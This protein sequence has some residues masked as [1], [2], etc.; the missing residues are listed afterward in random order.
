MATRVLSKEAL[1]SF[2]MTV[3]G[4]NSNDHNLAILVDLPTGETADNPDWQWRRAFALDCWRKLN[5]SLVELG[6]MAVSLFFYPATG[7]DG[8]DLPKNLW[9]HDSGD[10][11]PHHAGEILMSGETPLDQVFKGHQILWAL[12]EFSTTQPFKQAISEGNT[13]RAGTSP[14]LAPAALSV[15][16][17][18]PR[19]TTR[20]VEILTQLLQESVAA[21]IVFEVDGRL[22]QLHLDKDRQCQAHAS[23]GLLHNPG[24]VG[25]IPS[26]EAYSALR[27]NPRGRSKTRGVLPIQIGNTVVLCQVQN[28]R[29]VSVITKD[30]VSKKFWRRI[31]NDPAR[32]NIAELGFGVWRAVLKKPIDP[33]LFRN[34]LTAE[35]LGLH[36]ALGRDDGFGGCV[37]PAAFTSGVSEHIDHIYI[38]ECQPDVRMASVD[39]VMTDGSTVRIITDDEYVVSL[40]S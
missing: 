8:A 11:V 34:D 21:D 40:F 31:R 15:L 30:K 2:V 3:F 28:N 6:L 13:F 33:K 19:E 39:L 32:G 7:S 29:V 27:G 12:T 1:V 14:G 18:D 10:R 9:R 22:H 36:I 23:T 5:R 4:P 16:L 25:N 20:R 37:G 17:L 35:K 38:S 26:A 24:D